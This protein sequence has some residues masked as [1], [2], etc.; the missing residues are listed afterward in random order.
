MKIRSGFVSN[1][2]SSSFMAILTKED[3]EAVLSR[4]TAVEAAIAEQAEISTQKF[5]GQDCVV[6]Y[7]VSGNYSTLEDVSSTAVADRAREIAAARG[8][9]LDEVEEELNDNF[10]WEIE[11]SPFE[12]E[13]NKLVQQG[14]AITY[15]SY[16]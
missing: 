12:T 2:S 11:F 8:G 6:H 16:M 3:Y 4:L 5:M 7:H 14:K 15:S 10:L 1:S 9:N 13:I